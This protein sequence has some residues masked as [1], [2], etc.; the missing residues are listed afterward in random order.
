VEGR[1][2]WVGTDD[3][4]IHVTRDGG[5]T[6][7]D[8]TPA[9]IRD[10]SW[11]KISVMDAS[12]T[13]TLTAY[14]AISTLRLDD[15]RPHIYVTH[16]GGE[17][18]ERRV[19]GLPDF[20]FTNAVKEDPIRPG[21]LFAGTE[22]Q[23]HF[24]LDHGR[25]W[26]PLRLNMPATAIRDL[27]IK[28]DDLVV[29]THGRSFWILDDITPL[30]QIDASTVEQASMLFEP[31]EAWRVRWSRWTDTPLPTD[32]PT[33][34]SAPD[35]AILNYWVGEG[36]SGPVVLEV[37]DAA[38][39]IA[40]RF[41]SDDEPEPPLEGQN[42]PPWWIRPHQPLAASPGMNR[43]VW[44]LHYERP[45]GMRLR[46]PISA[47]PGRT[48]VEPRG[49]V[50]V[51]GEYTVR[52]TVGGVTHEQ[53]LVVKMDPRVKTPL[54]ALQEQFDLSMAIRKAM[55]VREEALERVR[56][57]G[58]ATPARLAQIGGQLGTLYG[59][60][61]GSDA[62]PLPRTIDLVHELVAEVKELVGD[63]TGS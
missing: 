30:R 18:W 26:S 47:V 57:S 43:F 21:L 42:V 61:Q 8:V 50:A 22:T 23:V 60:L 55:A 12:H 39:R 3:G 13:D 15:M 27:V 56:S 37:V 38:G 41:S 58:A 48:P 63:R 16:D 4:L 19:T 33:G 40:R 6:W 14:A 9:Q 59:I 2:I 49:P 25:N 17:S 32:E 11:S 53:T 1:W 35:G 31:A 34:E 46:Y 20:G 28:D 54:G 62:E 5:R 36:V 52:L 44:D 29:G 7:T 10:K 45:V 51:P 24:S